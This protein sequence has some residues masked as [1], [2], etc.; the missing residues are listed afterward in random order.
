[1]PSSAMSKF[2]IPRKTITKAADAQAV[3]AVAAEQTEL[4]WLVELTADKA[5]TATD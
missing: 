4:M 1:M 5:K 2:W 3:D